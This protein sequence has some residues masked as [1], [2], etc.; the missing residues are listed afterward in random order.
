MHTNKGEAKTKWCSFVFCRNK[1]LFCIFSPKPL[2]NFQEKQRVWPAKRASLAFFGTMRPSNFSHDFSGFSVKE[3]C[4]T[5]LEGGIFITSCGTDQNFLSTCGKIYC[6]FCFRIVL[7]G[8][9]VPP[10]FSRCFRLGKRFANFEGP[11]V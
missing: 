7:F 9:R 3:S 6:V 8:Q 4:F 11:F 5:S 1:Q 2:F 10:H